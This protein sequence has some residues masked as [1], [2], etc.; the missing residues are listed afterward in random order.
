ML[1][2][3]LEEVVPLPTSLAYIFPEEGTNL[4]S[5][6]LIWRSKSSNN[7]CCHVL[8]NSC[9][10]FNVHFPFVTKAPRWGYY[11]PPFGRWGKQDSEKS[12][13]LSLVPLLLTAKWRSEFIFFLTSKLVLLPGHWYLILVINYQKQY[14]FF[15]ELAIPFS[16]TKKTVLKIMLIFSSKSFF[17]QNTLKFKKINFSLFLSY[18]GESVRIEKWYTI[19]LISFEFVCG[20]YPNLLRGN[21]QIKS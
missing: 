20:F 15:S 9:W 4:Y 17:K 12:Y 21:W 6:K 18:C 1:S 13:S 3:L 19:I 2:K 7:S 5:D 11:C 16:K 14:K 8:F 10:A